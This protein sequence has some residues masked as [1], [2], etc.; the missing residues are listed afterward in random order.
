[1][2]RTVR[3]TFLLFFAALAL[4]VSGA[5]FLVRPAP[6]WVDR[7]DVATTAPIA[8]ESVRWGI[9]DLLKDH[10]VRAIGGSETQYFR[11]VRNVLSPSGV[12]NASELS[13]DFDPSFETL[14]IHEIKIVRGTQRIDALEPDDVRVIEKEEDADKRI[15]D[16]ER[17]ALIFL[18]DVRPGDVIDYSWS[19]EGANPILNGRY[20]DE[21]DL[22]SGAPARRM[23]HRLLWP[24]GA[25]LQ[26]H[27]TNPSIVR[28]GD[29]QT[30][31][32]EAMDVEALSVEDSV[33]SWFEPWQSI[34]LSSFGSWSEVARWA[35]AMFQLDARS[36]TEVKALAAT[37]RAANATRDAQL[38]AAIRFVQDDIRYLGIEMGRN[39]HQPH[40]P[41][42][43]LATRWGD[44]KDKTL[45]LVALL[46]ELG[47]SAYP[48]LVSTRL[49]HRIE[50]KLPSPFL[51]DHVIAQVIEGGRTYW[52]DGTI[53]EQGGTLATIETPNPRRALVVRPTTTALTAVVTNAKPSTHVEQSYTTRDFR[54]PTTLEVRTTYTGSDADAM[55]SE[56]ASISIEDF[57][58]SR[59][60]DLAVDQ[61][62]IEAVGAPT[63]RDDR[64]KN[65]IVVTERYRI[66]ELWSGGHW[67]WYP[68]VLD[69]H[70]ARPDTMIRSMP[71][72]FSYPLD[73]RQTVRFHFDTELDIEP[74]TAVTETPTFRYEYTVDSNGHTVTIRQSLRALRDVVP[75]K[76][77]PEHLTKLKAIWS[78]IGYRLAPEN[79]SAPGSTDERTS[80]AMWALGVF[81]VIA[82]V[83]L[84]WML[85]TSK[86]RKPTTYPVPRFRFAPG[87]AP[88]SALAVAGADDID[89]HLAAR[90]CT[91]GSSSYTSAE[92]Q[93]ARYAERELTIVTRQCGACGREQSIYFT[94]A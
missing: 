70:L 74:S 48:A 24:V 86:P 11:T 7:V 37:I 38:T 79:A 49:Q 14:I 32:W 30:L 62:K 87:E 56:L 21:Y 43:T 35:D 36:M 69:S 77:V 19:L 40:Q 41:W 17:T 51:F 34:Q 33:P 94:A 8:K 47:A 42:E 4:R 2:P 65:A 3:S 53:S 55:R 50:E 15:Y 28:N 78:E 27:G 91:C 66:R 25:P 85:A 1:M 9:Y 73:V 82:F 75:A 23:R 22:S 80:S 57:A 46:R 5:D 64:T 16:G 26:W 12:Q 88:V 52:I 63:I 90:A 6:A 83:G 20:A 60:N 68:R 13:L 81:I 29:V 44:C 67:T 45:L 10:Q 59:I 39:S 92:S 31:T 93:R 89:N 58:H 54:Q 72:A 76:D 71:L 84:C 61:P 18:K